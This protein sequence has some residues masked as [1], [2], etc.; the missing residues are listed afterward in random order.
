MQGRRQGRGIERRL[1]SAGLNESH[2]I[3]P[4]DFILDS[5]CSVK[6]EKVRAQSEQD[7]LAVV[8]DFARAGMLVGRGPAAQIGTALKQGNAKPAFGKRARGGES[9]KTAADDGNRT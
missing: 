8:H 5:D 9:G 3:E 7:V 1:S 2:A 6:G 4:A